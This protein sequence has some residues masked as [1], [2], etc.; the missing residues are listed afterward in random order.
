MAVSADDQIHRFS[1]G[2][3]PLCQGL[4]TI[5]REAIAVTAVGISQVA[6]HDHH[7]GLR[8]H[9]IVVVKDRIERVLEAQPCRGRGEGDVRSLGCG[10]ADQSHPDLIRSCADRQDLIRPAV[11]E[12]GCRPAGRGAVSRVVH[13]D[14]GDNKGVGRLGR[15]LAQDLLSPV[16]IVITQRRH[17][18]IHRIEGSDGGDAFLYVG[19][20]AALHRVARIH[21]Q[22]FV[23]ADSRAHAVNRRSDPRDTRIAPRGL[24]LAVEIVGVKD[25]NGGGSGRECEDREGDRHA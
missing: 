3:Q 2:V 5:N 7:V 19:E 14:V 20:Q 17:I 21:Q 24:Q 16:E 15:S 8:F 18:V 6:E 1:G 9:L 25:G 11:D 22:D 4:V 12:S 10:D 13:D 23:R